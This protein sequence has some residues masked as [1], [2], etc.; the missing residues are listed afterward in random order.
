MALI[1][2]IGLEFAMITIPVSLWVGSYLG[3]NAFSTVG[4][5]A[6]STV[7]LLMFFFIILSKRRSA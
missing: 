2:F 4:L 3:L 7:G 5:Y 1:G 6:V